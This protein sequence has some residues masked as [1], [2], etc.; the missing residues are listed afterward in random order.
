MSSVAKKCNE[1]ARSQRNL[2]TTP[3]ASECGATQQYIRTRVARGDW[4]RLHPG[5]YLIG[6]AAPDW[7]R[8]IYA[9][10]LAAGPGA[11]ASHRAAAALWGLEG[12]HRSVAEVT[13]PIDRRPLP[14][15]GVI[16]RT[17]RLADEDVTVRFGVPVTSIART[18]IDS[19]AVVPPAIV[20]RG[21]E[22]ALDR[23]LISDTQLARRLAVI[24]GRGCRGAGVL[25]KILATRLDGGPAGSFLEILAGHLLRDAGLTGWKRQHLVRL[26]TG[27]KFK[28]D[29]SRPEL[30]LAIE[31]EGRKGHRTQKEI[32]YDK[33]RRRMLTAMGWTVLTFTWHQVVN[34]PEE[35]I[36]AILAA[37]ASAARAA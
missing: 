32:A 9:F 27:E 36:A 3:Q 6:P 18:L 13:V 14:A 28:I 4:Q 16:H 26:H 21:V 15:G 29:L 10:V 35:V 19:G 30:L 11:R 33:W 7:E 1:V 34:S 23:K 17:G 31:L 8:R 24:G 5:V 22:D 37:V 12:S 25:R 2:I 20:E